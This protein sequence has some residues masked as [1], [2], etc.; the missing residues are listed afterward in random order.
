MLDESTRVRFRSGTH[1]LVVQEQLLR[2]ET[3]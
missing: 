2:Q 1:C 3:Q